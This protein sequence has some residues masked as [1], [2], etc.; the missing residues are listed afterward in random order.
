MFASTLAISYTGVTFRA[1]ERR[2]GHPAFA[3]VRQYSRTSEWQLRNFRANRMALKCSG[4]V[5]REPT[6][7]VCRARD[8]L[9]AQQR[10]SMTGFLAAEVL[11]ARILTGG[12]YDGIP[13]EIRA[14]ALGAQY[15]IIHS[16]FSL[17]KTL[18]ARAFGGRH[19]DR[20]A[21]PR[22]SSGGLL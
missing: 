20:S 18:S 12:G 11:N 15:Q 21:P 13:L 5:H 16:A 19:S 9:S 17:W 2:V 7:P 14:Y 6:R 4:S 3:A 22:H 1:S 8:P 10:M